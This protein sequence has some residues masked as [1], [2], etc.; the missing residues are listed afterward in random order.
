MLNPLNP[1]FPVTPV[2]PP[3]QEAVSVEIIKGK[4]HH[5][6]G[7]IQ[8]AL[9]WYRQSVLNHPTSS[10]SYFHLGE[11]LLAQNKLPAALKAYCKGLSCHLNLQNGDFYPPPTGIFSY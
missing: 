1:E 4:A 5:L 8:D 11:G 9:Y 6:R 7:E 10:L 2:T 3:S